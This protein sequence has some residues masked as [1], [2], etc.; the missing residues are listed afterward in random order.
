MSEV[1]DA[2][3]KEW[4]PVRPDVAKGVFGRTLLDGNVK[5]VLTRVAPGGK[6]QM[7]RDKYAHL[8]YFLSGEGIM[9]VGNEKFEVRSGLAAQIDAGEQHGYENTGSEEL[10][11]VSLNLIV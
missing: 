10:M 9:W 11:L 4:Q 2:S 1:F 8:F 5:A 7:H 3:S 6:F